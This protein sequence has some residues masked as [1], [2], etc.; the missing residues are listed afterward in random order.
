M[1]PGA[2]RERTFSLAALDSL[3]FSIAILDAEGTILEVNEGWV[4]FAGA[5]GG[6]DDVGRN[7]LAICDAAEG[8]G[9]DVSR[10]VAQGIRAVIAGDLQYFETEYP[11]H[12]P[13]R[14]QYF[15]ARV[16][17]LQGGQPLYMVIHEDI[18]QRRLAELE[19]TALNRTLEERVEERTRE[20]EASR[21][22]L[23]ELN[24]RLERSQ[25]EL[26]QKNAAL[27]ASNRDLAQF[28]FVASHDLQ[29]PLRTI[30]V[31]ADVLRHRYQ[32]TLDARAD[33]Y[34]GQIG[35]QVVRARALVRDVL[36]LARVSVQAELA[37]L[38]VAALWAD[39]TPTLP[40]PPDAR[41]SCDVLP[42]VQA[43]EGQIWQLLTNLLGNAIKFRSP[44]P[45]RV[46][47]S[48]ERPSPDRMS[49]GLDGE[50]VRFTLS[51]NGIGLAPEHAEQVFVMFKR[52]QS[53]GMDGGNGIG[54][55]VCKKIIERHG[56]RIWIDPHD[57]PGTTIHFTLPAA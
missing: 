43:N 21:A 52:L 26:E 37:P 24:A 48:A 22:A 2:V 18:S 3:L 51:D 23:S 44:A 27:E 11:C 49:P 15:R 8:E 53:R 33:G 39:L 7:Y 50:Q 13:Q 36:A 40:W 34:L 14:P 46:H 42:T 29:E 20:L 45:L 55:A 32:G 30:G 47:L 12:T 6:G 31:Y 17:A 56:G 16:S 28:A 19:V 54:L 9:S 35:D 57:G 41:W 4:A 1:T 25:R 38:D 5:N 10:A